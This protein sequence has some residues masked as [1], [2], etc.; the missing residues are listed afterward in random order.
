[1]NELDLM[2]KMAEVAPQHYNFLLKTA[3]EIK[4]S[5][6]KDEI[7]S[8][9]DS[10]V[11]AALDMRSIG[12]GMAGAGRALGGAAKPIGT[13]VGT[14]VVGGIAMALAGDMYDAAK[15]GITKSRDYK[16]MMEANPALK[17]LPSKT[18]QRTFSVLH[19]LNPEFASD[20]TVAGAWVKRQATFGEDSFA[21]V[22][23]L[24]SLID[25]RK[26]LTDSKRIPQVPEVKGVNSR[27]GM[28]PK[29]RKALGDLNAG[30]VDLD[31]RLGRLESP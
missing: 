26:S 1:M 14:A 19:R 23:Q 20:P 11:K 21:D 12:R 25:S 28:S 17:E 13:A 10:L 24:K 22:N 27:G 8:E 15:R 5:P 31:D 3:A 16:A 4:E 29:D 30:V 2:T 7:V 18:V 9:L 6:F